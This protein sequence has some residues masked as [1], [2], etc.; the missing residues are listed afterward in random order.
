MFFAVLGTLFA[1]QKGGTETQLEI[2]NR[3]VGKL[4]NH[5]QA[6]VGQVHD[7]CYGGGKIEDIEWFFLTGAK[8]KIMTP[9]IGHAVGTIEQLVCPHQSAIVA[10]SH[11]C[12]I[13]VIYETDEIFYLRS[14][15]A[16]AVAIVFEKIARLLFAQVTQPDQLT[17]RVRLRLGR[18][19]TRVDRHRREIPNWS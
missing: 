6:G 8:I 3:A 5:R 16:T 15:K 14:A 7:R 1:E 11:E 18:L 2:R 19:A 12:A 9:G 10:S 13:T 17:G 4:G